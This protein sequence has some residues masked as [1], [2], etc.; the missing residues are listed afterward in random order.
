LE[1][2]PFDILSRMMAS[3]EDSSVSSGVPTILGDDQGE[4]DALTPPSLP[5]LPL[6]PLPPMTINSNSPPPLGTEYYYPA[7][8]ALQN[9]PH[10]SE[11]EEAQLLLLEILDGC[12]NYVYDKVLS[13]IESNLRSVYTVG[14]KLYRREPLLSRLSKNFPIP[15]SQDV[16]VPL[17]TNEEGAKDGH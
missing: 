13:H 8:D 6:L 14:V 2:D 7:L 16:I 9:M 3:S 1:T 17:E 11:Q 5:P 4:D 10:L 12:P 15:T